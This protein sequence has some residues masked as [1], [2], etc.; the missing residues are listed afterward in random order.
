[1][2]QEYIHKHSP[3]LFSLP[4]MFTPCVTEKSSL[5]YLYITLM[6]NTLDQS[7]PVVRGGHDS[8]EH[9]GN[10]RSPLFLETNSFVPKKIQLHLYKYVHTQHLPDFLSIPYEFCQFYSH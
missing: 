7:L 2:H 5:R 8:G 1:M 9:G 6:L 3:T 4:S 10:L